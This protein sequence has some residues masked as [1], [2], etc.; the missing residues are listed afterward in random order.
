MRF[1][2]LVRLWLVLICTFL[3]APAPTLAQS[4]AVLNQSSMVTAR[5]LAVGPEGVHFGSGFLVGQRGHVVTAAHVVRTADS[6]KIAVLLHRDGETVWHYARLAHLLA[7]SDIAILH[8]PGLKDQGAALYS[9]TVEIGQPV[10]ALGFPLE[11]TGENYDP[12][13]PEFSVPVRTDGTVLGMSTDQRYMNQAGFM[14]DLV[15]HTA[16]LE[17]GSSGSALFDHCGRVIGVNAQIRPLRDGREVSVAMAI[18]PLLRV[19]SAGQVHYGLDRSRCGSIGGVT[20]GPA[21]PSGPVVIAGDGSRLPGA[22]LPLAADRSGSLRRWFLLGLA[23][24]VVTI[25][26]AV[27]YR[28]YSRPPPPER[29]RPSKRRPPLRPER[30]NRDTDLSGLTITR[31]LMKAQGNRLEVGRS[32]EAALTI[33]DNSVSRSHAIVTL[34]GERYSVFDFGSTNGTFIDGRQVPSHREVTVP[35]GAK[36]QFGQ[37]MVGLE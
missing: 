27:G 25:C 36:L 1:W 26:I 24:L 33:P 6:D 28:I 11:E 16:R 20:G 7:T 3:A 18:A 4:Q 2:A 30:H 5:I 34:S 31:A 8:V 9:G 35:P 19:L 13:R 12:E 15:D 22:V 29:L 17:Q 32:R 21:E 37:I 23:G 10:F 14:I